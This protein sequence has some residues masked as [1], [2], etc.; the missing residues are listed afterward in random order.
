MR[1]LVL[2][3]AFGRTEPALSSAV[4]LLQK[5][6]GRRSEEPEQP[7]PRDDAANAPADDAATGAPTGK[8][9][10]TVT[11]LGTSSVL[12]DAAPLP[13]TESPATESTHDKLAQ[14]S[15]APE[16]PAPF[17]QKP[18]PVTAPAENDAETDASTV[19]NEAAPAEADAQN[20]AEPAVDSAARDSA[21]TVPPVEVTTKTPT[22]GR[23]C[24]VP[25]RPKRELLDMEPPEPPQDSAELTN[26]SL[27]LDVSGSPRAKLRAAG[28]VVPHM[29]QIAQRGPV[30]LWAFGVRADEALGWWLQ[31]RQ[32]HEQT[33]WLPVLLGSA[34]DWLDNGESVL[35]E[36]DD[37]IARMRE[38]DTEQLLQDKAAEAGEPPRGVPILPTRG[39][40][41]FAVPKTD[42]LLGLVE[43][44][45]S[46]E[47]PAL[48]P[49]KGSTDW[50]LYGAEH[51][52]ILKR[53][54]ER[55]EVELV[56]MTW[57][58]ME[59][60][61]PSPPSNDEDVLADAQEVYAYCPDLL[62]AGVP[63]LDDLAVHMVRSRAWYFR[64]T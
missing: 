39:D 6:L 49:W 44:E 14:G 15:P 45:Y 35:H 12:S 47:I 7:K 10:E 31:I 1:R 26:D 24:F 42:G 2:A 19:D 18:E 11:S 9:E 27:P 8:K 13:E 17:D 3:F 40:S 38:I 53:W 41:D 28:V 48:L 63:T 33:G 23:D 56:S 60:Y 25:E 50:E 34:D 37:E 22:S 16:S 30:R 59:L 46:W 58:I 20:A 55:N 54:H 5:L 57:D 51:A 43:A 4:G 64:W 32:A 61:V 21:M 36:G 52:S 29:Q 62:A